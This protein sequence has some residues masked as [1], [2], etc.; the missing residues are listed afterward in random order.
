MAQTE[1]EVDRSNVEAMKKTARSDR[2]GLGQRFRGKD[3]AG[4]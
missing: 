1:C 2:S 3:H 4:H